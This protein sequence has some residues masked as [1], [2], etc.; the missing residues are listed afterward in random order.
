MALASAAGE[1][2]EAVAATESSAMA[3]S[4]SGSRSP[5]H[6]EP[7]RAE[8]SAASYVS[9]QRTSGDLNAAMSSVNKK[10]KNGKFF[11]FTR[12]AAWLR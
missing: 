10:L 6:S 8:P 9:L 12:D 7:R 5:S 4:R 11:L 1:G 3:S 2:Q